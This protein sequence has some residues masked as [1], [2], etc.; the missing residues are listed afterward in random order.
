[1]LKGAQP[2]EPGEVK[3][4]MNIE[5]LIISELENPDKNLELLDERRMASAL[6]S[7]V[8]KQLAQAIP[9]TVTHLID[10]KQ[11]RLIQV[12][13]AEESNHVD[14]PQNDYADRVNEV[15]AQIPSAS[16]QRTKQRTPSKPT[17]RKRRGVAQSPES[18]DSDRE[19]RNT[20][21]NV[22]SAESLTA[23]KL[24]SAGANRSVG[25]DVLPSSSVS[26]GRHAPTFRDKFV[27]DGDSEVSDE[28]DSVPAKKP[29]Q[30]RKRGEPDL[31]E[32]VRK[33]TRTRKAPSISSQLSQTQL[34]FSSLP[35]SKNRRRTKN[36]DD[37]SMDDESTPNRSYKLDEDWSNAKTDTYET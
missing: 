18:S 2:I 31:V 16:V 28:S 13:P 1:V 8:E 6:E 17:T 27:A 34:S 37:D 25:S 19:Y 24:R 36:D 12:G 15:G 30:K 4:E 3:G 21:G 23:K 9:D 7:Y 20:S 11:K 26:K 22:P 29:Y 14:I 5:D 33:G 32:T 10:K 35:K